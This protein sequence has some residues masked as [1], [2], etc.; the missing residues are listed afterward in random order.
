MHSWHKECLVRKLEPGGL[1]DIE[2]LKI[3]TE[4]NRV[5]VDL[6]NLST[7]L[8]PRKQIPELPEGLLKKMNF[9]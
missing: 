9:N 1:Q 2:A 6:F 3:A 8:I 7:F 4:K 5:F